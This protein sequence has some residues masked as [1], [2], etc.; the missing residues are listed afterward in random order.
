MDNWEEVVKDLEAGMK[1]RQLSK[2]HSIPYSTLYY[3]L[4]KA[5]L[6]KKKKK[7][8]VLKG[9]ST[10]FDEQ[11]NV[12]LQ[13]VKE[14]KAKE[15][16]LDAFKQALKALTDNPKVITP[17]TVKEPSGTDMDTMSVYTIGD[18]HIGMLA[19]ERETGAVNNIETTKRDLLEAMDMLVEQ[20]HNSKQA[21][22]IDVGDWFHSDNQT[23]R[24]AHSGNA[25]DVDG[26]YSEVLETGLQLTTMLIDKALAKHEEVRWRSAIGNHNEHSA[27]MMTAFIKA[28]YRN[29]PRV[30]VNDAPNMFD[31]TYF[32][33]NIVGVTH[34]HTVK[35][36]K[37]GEIMS[38]DCKDQWSLSDNRY[39]YTGHV[40]HQTVKE[41]SS[42][43][44]ETFCTLSGKDAWHNAAGYRSKQ[45]MKCITLHKDN[46]EISRNTVSLAMVRK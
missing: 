2:K 13:W 29:E 31:Y 14:D 26:R 15:N 39:W 12:K 22:I 35:A 42:C 33:R 19:T 11:G 7:K 4:D 8:M 16:V 3:K 9:T 34:G 5:G 45:S 30:I 25:L 37:L 17:T 10:L 46:G 27:L 21:F 1:L 36:E 28:W 6:L 18:A 20:A 24:T 23:N 38:V 32:G 40:H 41:F 44:V 43:V